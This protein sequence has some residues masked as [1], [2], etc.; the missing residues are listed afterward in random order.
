[1]SN[2]SGTHKNPR[3]PVEKTAVEDDERTFLET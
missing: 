3:V 2:R 1:V